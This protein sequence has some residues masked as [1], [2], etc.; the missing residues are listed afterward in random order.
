MIL[1][2]L[3]EMKPIGW[4]L[5]VIWKGQKEKTYYDFSHFDT[6]LWVSDSEEKF[7]GEDAMKYRVNMIKKDGNK[8]WGIAVA[9]VGYDTVWVNNGEINV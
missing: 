8:K 4:M 3:G 1:R 7:C 9:D 5:W 2:N 6:E